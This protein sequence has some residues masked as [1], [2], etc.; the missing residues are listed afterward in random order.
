MISLKG[1]FEVA[2]EVVINTLALA[3]IS[4]VTMVCAFLLEQLYIFLFDPSW[5]FLAENELFI[6]EVV[7]VAVVVNIVLYLMS[8]FMEDIRDRFGQRKKREKI[9][10]L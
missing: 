4:G 9:D 5:I 8:L 1:L 3:M 2:G 6:T 10:T 7:L